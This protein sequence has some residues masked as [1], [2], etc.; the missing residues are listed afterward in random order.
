[1][2]EHKDSL[3]HSLF[4]L[5]D[6]AILLL[7]NDRVVHCNPA[8]VKMFKAENIDRILQCSPSDFSPI[9]QPDGKSSKEKSHEMIELAHKNG[10]AQFDW[11][12]CRFDGNNFMAEVVLTPFT[13]DGKQL[14]YAVIRDI[15]NWQVSQQ[16][17][18]DAEDKLRMI[19][20]IT[21]DIIWMRDLRLRY[22]Y[23]S[24]SVER[25]K[26]WT[27]DEAM[28]M[29]P[30]EVAP[31]KSIKK[32]LSMLQQELKRDNAPGLDPIRSRRFQMQEYCKDGS[33]IWTEQSMSFIRDSNKKPIGFLGITRNITDQ[34]NVLNELEAAKKRAEES[35][36]L[37]SSFLAN[38]SHEIRT[39]LNAILGFSELMADEQSD[40]EERKQFSGIIKTSTNSLL[41]MITDIF[42]ISKLRSNQLNLKPHPVILQKILDKVFN[43]FIYHVP[44][45]TSAQIKFFIK[46][47]SGKLNQVYLF[48]EERLVQILKKMLENA[49]KYTKEGSISFGVS[50]IKESKARFFV[51][52]TG[53][54]IP[55]EKQGIIFKQFRQGEE[56]LKRQ[57]GGT[58]LGLAICKELVELM[59][60]D[61]GVHSSPGSGSEF[62]FTLPLVSPE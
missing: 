62:W 53:T 25:V 27:V 55:P 29:K 35:D 10:L 40:L 11:M 47:I 48:D 61:I 4:M 38:M 16:A 36:N 18:N 12:H 28:A 49:F 60:G 8:C 5:A 9:L 46:P 15:S 2:R 23:L 43:D 22:T 42:D 54:G 17:L 57:F 39:P 45:E 34:Q 41:S 37:K 13:N 44:D 33:L 14:I 7:E 1:M 30:T 59:D 26:G 6:D 52:D 51:K 20:S 32:A 21:D 56:S 58:G 50:L 31:P 3:Y 24:P 19:A